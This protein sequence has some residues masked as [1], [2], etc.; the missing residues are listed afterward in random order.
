M[1][2]IVEPTI[3]NATLKIEKDLQISIFWYVHKNNEIH[4]YYMA[5]WEG[6]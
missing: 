3:F 5:K 2:L 4:N 6:G 1:F